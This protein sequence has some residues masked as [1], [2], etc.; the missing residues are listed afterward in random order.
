MQ[1]RSKLGQ[2]GHPEGTG[3]VGS[4]DIPERLF[5]QVRPITII[6]IKVVLRSRV[7]I[8]HST[9]KLFDIGDM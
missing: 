9:V 8:D 2:V 1:H 6:I 4:P 5:S 7:I 3:T